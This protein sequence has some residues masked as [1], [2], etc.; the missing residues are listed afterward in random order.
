MVVE[1]NG[2]NEEN[3]EEQGGISGGRIDAVSV[4]ESLDCSASPSSGLRISGADAFGHRHCMAFFSS[5]YRLATMA[6]LFFLF[7]CHFF[8]FFFFFLVSVVFPA[9]PPLPSAHGRVE[10]VGIISLLLLFD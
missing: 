10:P 2:G 9:P 7:C 6:F 5:F 4:N 3:E 8:F 1:C